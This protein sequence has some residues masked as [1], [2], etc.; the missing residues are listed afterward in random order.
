[1]LKKIIAYEK[2]LSQGYTM[3]KRKGIGFVFLIGIAITFLLRRLQLDLNFFC[4]LFPV[5]VWLQMGIILSGNN[6]LL[7]SLAVSDRFAV[8]NLLYISPLLFVSAVLFVMAAMMLIGFLANLFFAEHTA[9]L[10]KMNLFFD[11]VNLEKICFT[12]CIFAGIWCW[13]G[14]A[15]FHRAKGTRRLIVM[16]VSVIVL[17]GLILMN[18]AIRKQSGYQGELSVGDFLEFA[19]KSVMLVGAV[20]FMAG[21]AMF[22][23]KRSLKLYRTDVRGQAKHSADEEI[24][25][26]SSADYSQVSARS[27]KNA[28]VKALLVFICLFAVIALTFVAVFKTFDVFVTNGDEKSIDMETC[29]IEDYQDWNSITEICKMPED[30]TDDYITVIFP[31]TID[32]NNVEQYYAKGCGSYSYTAGEEEDEWSGS[33]DLAW[34]RFLA[35][36]LPEAD[37]EKEKQ[38]LA[39]LS[40]AY[41]GEESVEHAV[42]SVLKDTEHFAYEAYIAV[43]DNAMSNYEYALVDDSSQRIIYVFTSNESYRSIKTDYDISPTK[44]V[45]VIPLKLSNDQNKAYSIYSFWGAG[46]YDYY[47]PDVK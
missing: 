39:E 24:I 29:D 35:V 22:A 33:Y 41:Q 2:L 12:I 10:S 11:G 27:S 38:R 5:F 18:D 31:K 36:S 1:M 20:V 28:G 3:E 37:Y 7:R 44:S 21:S 47:K 30:L 40:V 14:F 15:A 26:E 8:A 34:I 32:E 6:R 13:M 16:L 43:W 45:N 17:G 4:F 19:D 23:W 25:Y 46:F 42:N 9:F